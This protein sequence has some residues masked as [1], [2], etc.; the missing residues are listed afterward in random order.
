M[1]AKE[2]KK[3]NF[4]E[5]FKELEEIVRWFESSEVDLEEGLKKFERGLELAKKCRGRLAEVENKVTQIKEK[6]S[7]FA[8]EESNIEEE[9]DQARLL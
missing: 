8:D 4:A 5:A 7:G 9:D 1:P 3:A 6:F 2:A